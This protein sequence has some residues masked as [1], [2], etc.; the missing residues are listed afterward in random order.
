MFYLHY[1]LLNCDGGPITFQY[2]FFESINVFSQ[3]ENQTIFRMMYICV[4]RVILD[5]KIG[6]LNS[7]NLVL[8]N[9]MCGRGFNGAIRF[10][11]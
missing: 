9:F 4:I 5:Q 11:S 8:P 6:Q 3:E 7:L 1:I 2:Y 10:C